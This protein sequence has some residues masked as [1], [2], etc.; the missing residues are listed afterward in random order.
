MGDSNLTSLAQTFAGRPSFIPFSPTFV[1][2][3][4]TSDNTTST[5][6]PNSESASH[7]RSE[8]PE[9]KVDTVGNN[10]EHTAMAAPVA[11]DLMDAEP[12]QSEMAP[13]MASSAMMDPTR[14]ISSM[15]ST[16]MVDV[17]SPSQ[18]KDM[19]APMAEPEPGPGQGALADNALVTEYNRLVDYHTR[20]PNF[21]SRIREPI[22]EFA[23]EALGTFI[24]CLAG[25]GTN[26][27]VNLGARSDIAPSP[28]GDWDSTSWAWGLG[29]ALAI[30]IAGG[31]S[32]GHVNPAV[33]LSFAIFRRFPWR[34]VPAYIIAQV[35]GAF[36]AGLLCYLNYGYAIAIYEG[37][38]TIHS[39]PGT[40]SFISCYALDYVANMNAFIDAFIGSLILMMALFAV[41]DRSNGGGVR[42][43][44]V[45]LVAFA[46]VFVVSSGFGSQTSFVLNP[47]R[48][49][50]PRLAT[51]LVGYG[52]AVWTYRSQYWL[53]CNICGPIIGAAFGGLLY[54]VFI[55]VGPDSVLNRPSRAA[56]Q[57]AFSTAREAT[58]EKA[59]AEEM[60]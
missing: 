11:E 3:T 52:P 33:T 22:R 34:K 26:L 32:G 56:R 12:D 14:A 8:P 51:F 15:Q 46:A 7:G 50:G 6:M 9:G 54:E 21:W 40:A 5:D 28:R 27:Q 59:R 29:L 35:L 38:P 36:L 18:M 24:L 53:W 55:N 16:T 19:A 17:T 57:Y 60:A 20:Y 25:I 31:V 23:A 42:R 45:P 41:T 2:P 48:D 13:A 1:P 10:A 4:S 44:L 39:V 49:F 37:S 58:D 30:W 43:E 47:A